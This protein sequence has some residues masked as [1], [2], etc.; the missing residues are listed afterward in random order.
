MS[1]AEI[2]RHER[3][4]TWALWATRAAAVVGFLLAITHSAP[5]TVT[6]WLIAPWG[7]WAFSQVVI[8]MVR[9]PSPGQLRLE[10]RAAKQVAYER[11]VER[12]RHRL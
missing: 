7:L 6:R 2:A 11:A 9:A 8:G 12:A 3:L 5:W 10:R 4:L 1:D